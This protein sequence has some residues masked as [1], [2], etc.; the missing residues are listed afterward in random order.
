MTILSKI[1]YRFERLL[2]EIYAVR[3]HEE[4]QQICIDCLKPWSNDF[5]FYNY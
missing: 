3:S 2:C 5:Y 1:K 4:N